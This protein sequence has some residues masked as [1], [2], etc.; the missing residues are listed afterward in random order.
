MFKFPTVTTEFV[1]KQLQSMPENKAVGLDKLPG[2]LLRAAAPIIAQPLAFI[3]NLSLQSGNFINE[4]KHA[5]VLPLHKTRPQMERNNYRPI[6]ILPIL[7]K[8]L[9][10]FVHSNFS[11]FLDKHNHITITQSG[12]RKLHSTV[13]ALLN[14]TDKWLRNI[15]NGLVTGV[16]FIDLHK[17]FN[18]VDIN[19]LLSKLSLFGISG[20]ELE[21]FRSYL[22]GRSQSVIFDG[23]LSDPLPVSIGV[24]QGSIL[25]ALLFLLY[26]NDLPKIAQNCSVNMF[27]D[28]TEMEDSCKPEDSIKLKINLNSDLSRLKEYF[29]LN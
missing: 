9:E 4:W 22:T 3:L 13:T 25:G 29:N 16:V 23:Y 2:K 19:I 20:V 26:L 18:T 10:R 27:A 12:F 5:K 17:A 28:D 6:S 14:V 11:Q 1:L 7:S 8:I 21:W 24:P 15:D